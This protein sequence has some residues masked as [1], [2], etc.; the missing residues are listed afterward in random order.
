MNSKIFQICKFLRDFLGVQ[1][2]STKINVNYYDFTSYP[3]WVILDI[4]PIL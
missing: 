4:T 1:N 3:V 2:N